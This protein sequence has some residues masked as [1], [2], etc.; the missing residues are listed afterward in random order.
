MKTPDAEIGEASIHPRG[1][2]TSATPGLY[3][4]WL[5]SLS[6][7]LFGTGVFGAQASLYSELRRIGSLLEATVT[8][9]GRHAFDPTLEEEGTS[10]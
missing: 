2:G 3:V 7:G 4:R 5:L 8:F 10:T 6:S 9:A 1:L